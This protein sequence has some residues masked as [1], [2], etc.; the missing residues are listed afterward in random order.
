M[1]RL[2]ADKPEDIQLKFDG[3]P[4]KQLDGAPADAV[5]SSLQAL[6]RMVYIIGMR[7]EGRN[8]SERL[9]P[10][11]KVKREYAIVCRAPKHGSHIQP[12]NV[13]SQAGAFTPAAV[14]AREKLLKT[15]KAFDSGEEEAVEL[16]LPNARERWFMAKA[17]LGLLPPEDSGLEVTVRAGSRGP[18]NFKADRARALLAK[19][20]T[21]EPPEVDEEIVAGKLQ[22]IDFTRTILTVKPSHDPAIRL[23]YPLPLEEWLKAN[24]RKRLRFTGRPKINQKGDVSSFKQIDSVT[25]LEP[26]LA[27][28]EEFKVDNHTIKA[29]RPLSIP[30]T[31]EWDERLFI[32]QDRSIGVDAYASSYGELRQSV[33]DE[34]GVLWRNY[35]LAQDSELDDE[36]QAVKRA[37]LSRFKVSAE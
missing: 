15:L 35:A 4:V 8:L 17:A 34:L 3:E 12:F 16:A 5:I 37:L 18:F 7:S 30:V 29:N 25:E 36:A 11:A 22:A 20:D 32:F 27:P 14:A 24:V 9:K 1:G 13:A 10:T 26:S 2:V 23:D 28:V 6:Q 31:V 33:L 19:Y 21:A